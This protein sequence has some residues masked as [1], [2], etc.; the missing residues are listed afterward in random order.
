MQESL[1]SHKGMPPLSSSDLDPMNARLPYQFANIIDECNQ[2]LRMWE[3]ANFEGLKSVAT[4]YGYG[5]YF[6]GYDFACYL[7][8]SNKEWFTKESHTPIWLSIQDSNWEKNDQY[9]Y[10]LNKEKAY[11]EKYSVLYAIILKK[12]MDK[13]EIVKHIVS[14]VKHVLTDLK[15]KV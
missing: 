2:S 3:N 10:A 11:N 6:R 12:G 14:E 5:F 1:L 13:T 15:S 4:K 7:Y 8:Y 9:Y